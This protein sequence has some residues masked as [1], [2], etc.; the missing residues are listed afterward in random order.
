[1]R[2]LLKYYL[3]KERFVSSK[4]LFKE[5][6]IQFLQF[7]VV[8]AIKLCSNSKFTNGEAIPARKFLD[9]AWKSENKMTIYSVYTFFLSRNQRLRNST[10]FLKSEYF[11]KL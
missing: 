10:E 5:K 2:L 3:S 8:D 9:A 11:F 6:I 4:D 7:K 1:M